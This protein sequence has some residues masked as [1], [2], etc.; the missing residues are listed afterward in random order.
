MPKSTLDSTSW[1]V[2]SHFFPLSHKP[3]LHKSNYEE[4]CNKTAGDT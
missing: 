1:D 4:M 2:I 3:W